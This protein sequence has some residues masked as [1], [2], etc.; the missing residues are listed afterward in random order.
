MNFTYKKSFLFRTILFKLRVVDTNFFKYNKKNGWSRN[1]NCYFK[2]VCRKHSELRFFN[3]LDT[4]LPVIKKIEKEN[5]H[6]FEIL[7][8]GCMV[9]GLPIQSF[10]E[11]LNWTQNVFVTVVNYLKYA[12]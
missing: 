4:L 10:D 9:Q 1:D 5:K 7:L 12:E 2:F 3:S 11:K 8:G 6:H